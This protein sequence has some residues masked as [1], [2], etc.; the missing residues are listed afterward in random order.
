MVLNDMLDHMN[1]INIYSTFY[2]KTAEY[3]YFLS[4]H[5]AF[6]IIDHMFDYKTS[7][8]KFKRIKIISSI[9]S[10]HNA[11]KLVINHKKKAEKS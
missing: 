6:S 9:F 3:T 1:L 8:Y 10:A 7:L 2:S 11:M 5:Q 4:A